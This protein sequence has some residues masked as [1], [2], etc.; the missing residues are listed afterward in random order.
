MHS[1]RPSAGAALLIAA[2][3]IV[4]AA[5]TVLWTAAIEHQ[6][7]AVSQQ[8]R[9]QGE[10]ELQKLCAD[11]GTMA[12]IPP[13]AGAPAANPSRGYEQAEHRAWLGLTEA[14][15]CPGTRP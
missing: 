3:F 4:N 7:N 2:V 11:I 12:A 5:F 13:P 10:K 6:L 1:W 15:Q 8:E 14:I 9:Q